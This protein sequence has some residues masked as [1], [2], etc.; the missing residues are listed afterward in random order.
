MS[1][2]KVYIMPLVPATEKPNS[3]KEIESMKTPIA[4]A[5]DSPWL[6]SFFQFCEFL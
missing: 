1:D 6:P 4:N 2:Q 3:W 5:S